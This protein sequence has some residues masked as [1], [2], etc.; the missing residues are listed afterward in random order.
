M[1][2]VRNPLRPIGQ[3]APAEREPNPSPMGWAGITVLGLAAAGG[4]YWLYKQ[5]NAPGKKEPKPT[6]TGN[7]ADLIEMGQ[8]LAAAPAVVD[9]IRQPIVL[10]VL[11]GVPGADQVPMLDVA[12][13]NPGAFDTVAFGRTPSGAAED[14]TYTGT[15]AGTNDQASLSNT[16]TGAKAIASLV[17]NVTGDFARYAY[18]FS[19]AKIGQQL[20]ADAWGENHDAIIMEVLAKIAPMVDWSAGLAPFTPSDPESMVWTATQLLGTVA[21]Q[22]YWNKKAMAMQTQ[23]SMRSSR[24]RRGR[25]M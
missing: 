12:G 19:L 25:R 17:T 15:Y 21:N 9:D 10:S 6:P 2:I 8:T 1:L 13:Y 5:M 11:P 18:E 4:G 14:I 3:G 20:N 24:R 16:D 22:S 7:V 23:M